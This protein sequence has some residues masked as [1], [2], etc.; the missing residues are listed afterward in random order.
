MKKISAAK[1]PTTTAKPNTGMRLNRYLAQC[2]LGARRKVEEYILKGAIQLNGQVVQSLGTRIQAHDQLTYRGKPLQCKQNKY[3]L[4]NKPPNCLCTKQGNGTIYEIIDR[5]LYHLN[6]IG[7]L[8]RNTTGLLL[9]SND[10]ALAHQL[11]HPTGGVP[12]TYMVRTRPEVT[13]QDLQQLRKG[14]V[15]EDGFIRPDK[16]QAIGTGIQITLHSG[17]NRIIRRMME[18]LDYQVIALDRTAYGPLRKGTLDQG[19]W[20]MLTP[21]EVQALRAYVQ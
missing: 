13:N 19:Y 15:L 11:A 10:G 2:G 16:L 18:A 9:L 3:I 17:R 1:T 20:R 12:K 6:Y 4:L 14:I 5:H 21:D 7:R 8:D